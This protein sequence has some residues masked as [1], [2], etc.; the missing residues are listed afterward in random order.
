M[1]KPAPALLPY[2]RRTFKPTP[3]I[4]PALERKPA[5]ASRFDPPS[6]AGLRS[7]PWPDDLK[8]EF[9]VE[10]TEAFVTFVNNL[11]RAENRLPVPQ[12]SFPARASE[13]DKLVS[14]ARLARARQQKRLPAD[15]GTSSE[16]GPQT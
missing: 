8:Q 1:A 6:Y 13:L 9:A 5:A 7:A 4:Q 16:S 11:R 12:G 15:P 14:E 3:Q 2:F 10:S